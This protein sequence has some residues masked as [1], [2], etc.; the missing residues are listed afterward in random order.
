MDE[1]ILITFVVDVHYELKKRFIKKYSKD[2]EE[3]YNRID[4]L[5]DL[6]IVRDIEHK[7]FY[8]KFICGKE[9]LVSDHKT[10]YQRLFLVYESELEC[11][12]FF[13]HE[14][15]S[16]ILTIID[17][18][19]DNKILKITSIDLMNEKINYDYYKGYWNIF[20]LI[21][22]SPRLYSPRSKK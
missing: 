22:D 12:S 9:P 7:N 16:N 18:Y 11:A 3:F 6:N 15:K 4:T 13:V 19:I 1:D 17:K 2:T 10:E 20:T 21:S 8:A 5:L 14:V